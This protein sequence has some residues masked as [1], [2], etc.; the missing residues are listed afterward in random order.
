VRDYL[1]LSW[2][3]CPTLK[4]IICTNDNYNIYNNYNDEKAS[5]NSLLRE[6]DKELITYSELKKKFEILIQE[7]NHEHSII[8]NLAK[9]L[10]VYPTRHNQ[11]IEVLY[12][13]AD[14]VNDNID[15]PIILMLDFFS[16][17]NLVKEDLIKQ[18]EN[19]L[20]PEELQEI[21]QKILGIKIIKNFGRNP[22]KLSNL[23]DCQLTFS[24]K[25]EFWKFMEKMQREIDRVWINISSLAKEWTHL[26]INTI[27]RNIN[28]DIKLYLIN[29]IEGRNFL[30]QRYSREILEGL[31]DLSQLDL[32]WS[33]IDDGKR[34]CSEYLYSLEKIIKTSE[35]ILPRTDN[36]QKIRDNIQHLH[37]NLDGEI[38]F[39]RRA[40]DTIKISNHD[41]KY[42]QQKNEEIGGWL[43]ECQNLKRCFF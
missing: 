33:L 27:S 21:L 19:N 37:L 2:W 43:E 1:D 4:D 38:Y 16:E 17:K 9:C 35:K 15:Q 29:I 13:L 11:V 12:I 36:I 5:M 30:L 42:L 8:S 3:D 20:Q 39:S 26:L 18:I 14:E 23:T 24:S 7:V 28:Q 10:D 6:A 31:R 34:F 25:I 40:L 32:K 41:I 22:P